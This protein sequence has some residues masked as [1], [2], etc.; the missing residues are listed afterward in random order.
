VRDLEN[1]IDTIVVLEQGR[2]IFNRSTAD[3]SDNL[4]FEHNLNGYQEEEILYSEEITGKRAGIV[5]NLSGEETRIDLELLF[6]GLIKNSETIN[7]NFKKTV[8]DEQQL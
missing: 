5:R 3:I 6:N 8:R 4:A 2:I 7:S 1:L